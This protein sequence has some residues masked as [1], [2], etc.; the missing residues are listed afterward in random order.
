V[1]TKHAILR[2]K[3]PYQSVYL[4]ESGLNILIAKQETPVTVTFRK[5]LTN[6]IIPRVRGKMR[7]QDENY[8]KKLGQ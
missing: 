7:K 5:W 3:I 6:K 4:N 8:S 2:A 1:S